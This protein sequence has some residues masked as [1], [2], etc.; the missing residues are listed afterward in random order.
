MYEPDGGIYEAMNKG[1]Q[2]AT[3]D[4]LCFLNADDMYGR[5]DA[6]SVLAEAI[7]RQGAD[8]AHGDLVYVDRMD[9]SRRVRLWRGRPHLPGA[10]SR[11]WAPAHP[12]L[13]AR[14]ALVRQI[15]GFDCR[16][17]LA[18]DFDLM[19]RLLEGAGARSSYVPSELVRMRVGGV[20][21]GSLRNVVRQNLE[22][23][24]ALRAGGAAANVGL[25]VARKLLSRIRQRIEARPPSGGDGAGQ[26][27]ATG[28]G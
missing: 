11:G 21:S 1:L 9:P 13:L 12:T 27:I 24:D 8:A 22:I 19:Y 7:E 23:L 25:F 17:R 28:N 18:A 3:G 15:G 5:T 2:W 14:T 16:F 4:F 10:F 26:G 6:L 20:T